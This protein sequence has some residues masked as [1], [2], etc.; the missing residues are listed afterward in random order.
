M[1]KNLFK[2]KQGTQ[3]YAPLSG[4]V[5]QL[6]KVPDPVFSEK[7]M[8]EGIAVVPSDATV[9]APF[10]GKVIQVPDTRHAVGLVDNEENEVLI[11]IGL[12]TVEL[13]GEGFETKVQTGDEV[14]I[15]QPLL[16][17][18]LDYLQKNAKDMITPIVVT[19]S[20][21]SEKNFTATDETEAKA[22]E[23]VLM[24]ISGK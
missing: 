12:D 19:N 1:F 4:Q 6:E 23:T 10:D 11:H 24:T 2:K 9:L 15:G 13:K 17:L 20:A 5:V 7:M 22:G 14:K 3:I 18:D 8:G 16:E 21:N